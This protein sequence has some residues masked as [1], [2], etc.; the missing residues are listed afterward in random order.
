ML[1]RPTI[2]LP[3]RRLSQ[4]TK[5]P[6]KPKNNDESN[7]LLSP[8]PPIQI[9]SS[10]EAQPQLSTPRKYITTNAI[11]IDTHSVNDENDSTE[12]VES[13][14]QNTEN[15]QCMVRV[16]PLLTEIENRGRVCVDIDESTNMISIDCKPKPKSFTFD[17]VGA[18]HSTQESI[19]Q[20][21]G[22]PITNAC[23]SGYN[24]TIFAYGM[25]CIF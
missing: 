11:D 17:H 3:S 25:Y 15:I 12:F 21:V 19:F 4:L 8:Q 14:L 24:S 5:T 7:Q 20:S 22:K 6:N 2:K 23:L 18:M 10:H 16:R 9:E 1:Q 13:T